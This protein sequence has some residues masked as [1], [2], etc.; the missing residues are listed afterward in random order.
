MRV[1]TNLAKWARVCLLCVVPVLLG[2]I[3]GCSEL[4]EKYIRQDKLFRIASLDDQ[5]MFDS[6]FIREDYLNDPDPE[7]RAKTAI[8]IGRIGR[9]YYTD[10]LLANLADTAESAAAAKFFAAG[11]IGD[12]V[13]FE[14]LIELIHAGTPAAGRAVEA[15]GR[16][17]DSTRAPRIAEFLSNDD[18]LI[19]YQAMLAM[20]RANEWSAAQRIADIGAATGRKSIRYAAAYSLWRGRRSEGRELFRTL[21][22]DADPEV[23][24]LAYSGLGRIADT[25]SIK[26]IATGLNDSDNR[27]I[28]NSIYALRAFG[29]MGA[30]YVAKKL[31]E[32]KDEKLVELCVETLGLY[33]NVADAEKLVTKALREDGRENVAGTAAKSLL[34]IKGK[35]ALFVIDE[36]LRNP[37]DWQKTKITEGLAEISNKDAALSRLGQLYNDESPL[38]R[39][40]ALDALCTIDSAYV[41]TY[42]ETSLEDADY[43]VA[44]VAA[45]FAGRF[46]KT[47][48][49]QTLADLYLDNPHEVENDLKISI[50][51][52]FGQFENH[53]DYDSLIIAVLEEGA[54]DEWF[55][56]RE[57]AAHLLKDRYKIDRLPVIGMART[58]IDKFN[59]A[60]RFE[61]YATNPTAVIKTQRGDIVFELLYKQAPKTVNNFIALAESGFYDS[62]VFHRVVPNFVIQD[63]CPEGTGWGGPGYT[64]RCEYNLDTYTTG[65]VGMAHSGMDTGGSQYFITLSPQPHLDG[66][67]TLFGRV[68]SGMDV[69]Q[70]IVRGDRITSVR[71]VYAEE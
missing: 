61:K 25:A 5:R 48:F 40:A 31:P 29:D 26:L 16:I 32:L 14:P 66:R 47:E 37:T 55:F 12:T 9:G 18:S 54:N 59:Y 69:V 49:I 35:D 2:L 34:H 27:V 57:K 36:A 39:L 52:A 3:A 67:Y 22:A 6:L 60:D 33:P 21:I 42:I 13:F 10:Y 38:V 63:G 58:S 1:S 28:A 11:L 8:A 4:E 70:N 7:I 65:A 44:S 71:I 20:F 45:D 23:R 43:V 50:I 56:I 30:V 24:M 15:L 17:A 46:K 64:I 19:V 62:L 53:P 51:D 41:A 68:T